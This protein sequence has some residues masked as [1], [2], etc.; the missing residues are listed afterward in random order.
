VNRAS[1]DK[2]F[3][4]M[5]AAVAIF[6]VFLGCCSNVVFLE[7]IV[8][9]DPGAGNLITFAQFLFIALEGF[10]FTSKFGTSRRNIGFQ[11]YLILVIMFFLANICNN[12]AFDFNVPMPLHIIFRSGSLI[13][14]MM[15][16]ILILKKKYTFSKYLSVL[17]I[18]LGIIICTIV[19]GRDVKSTATR[20]PPTTPYEDFF[21]WTIGITLLVAA[22]VI[23]A[24]MGLY[25]ETLFQRFG[26]HPKEALFYTHLLPLP[27]FLIKIQ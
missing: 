8:K 15:M 23:T 20:G 1:L 11:H 10:I 6:L 18:T 16:G 25:Q 21:W 22:L 9:E 7:L 13:T 12:W 14:N 2:Y 27:F 24:R 26:K 4:K 5:N 17:M 19:S 3:G